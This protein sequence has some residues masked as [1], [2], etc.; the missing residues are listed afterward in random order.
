MNEAELAKS[1]KKEYNQVNWFFA[2][3]GTMLTIFGFY[4]FFNLNSEV[5]VSL[6]HLQPSIKNGLFTAL[7]GLLFLVI[8]IY[9]IVKKRKLLK[10]LI[11]ME[12]ND[13]I[14]K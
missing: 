7:I 3:I 10:Q 11:R 12:Q 8:L 14:D 5:V 9:R 13:Q 4:K 6:R 1:V 2:V